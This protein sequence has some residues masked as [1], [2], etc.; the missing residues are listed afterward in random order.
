MTGAGRFTVDNIDPNLC[1]DY[2]YAFTTLDGKTFQM[3]PFDPAVDIDGEGYA[4]FVQMKARNPNIKTWVAI[5]GWSDSHESD[6][7][8]QLVSS[9]ENINKFVQSAYSFLKTYGF[10]GLDIDWE[11][12]MSDSDKQGL[13]HLL[14]YMSGVFH[15]FGYNI[16]IAMSVNT[17][18]I[19]LGILLLNFFNRLRL[20]FVN[21]RL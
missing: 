3:K 2:V 1:T 20:T 19:D 11:F 4:K 15:A 9:D 14:Y 8:S 12:P 21:S 16:S 6:K 5:G 18:I 10:D 13:S 7:Y 17:T